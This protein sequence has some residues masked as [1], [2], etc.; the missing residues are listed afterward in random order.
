[1]GNTVVQAG[2]R[3]FIACAM[4]F[5]VGA[6]PAIAK[7]HAALPDMTSILREQHVESASVALIREGRIVSL[8]AW[9]TAGPNRPAT[10]STP[11]NLA[12][13]TNHLLQIYSHNQRDLYNRQASRCQ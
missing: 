2:L 13:L 3:L 8:A 6:N 5:L 7:Q 12:S 4:G 11:Y 1:M 10:V 9:G